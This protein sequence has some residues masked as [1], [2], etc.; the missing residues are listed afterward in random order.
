MFIVRS[1]M[2]GGWS[3]LDQPILKQ[4]MIYQDGLA[5]R[6]VL[7]NGPLGKTLFGVYT[8]SLPN[9]V[10][11]PPVLSVYHF[12]ESPFELDAKHPGVSTLSHSWLN[13]HRAW[14]VRLATP[15]HNHFGKP[16]LHPTNCQNKAPSFWGHNSVS[17]E[18][19]LTMSESNTNIPV[20]CSAYCGLLGDGLANGLGIRNV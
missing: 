6:L 19:A 7:H 10:L 8:I 2:Y 4:L 1:T 16:K 3:W 13:L 17:K 12:T 20:K 5:N 9:M 18:T 14:K 11:K 15:H